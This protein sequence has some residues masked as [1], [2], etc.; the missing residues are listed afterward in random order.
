M[1][2]PRRAGD[3][4]DTV[5][6]VHLRLGVHRD[7]TPTLGRRTESRWRPTGPAHRPPGG[8][9]ARA[10]SGVGVADLV[11]PAVRVPRGD[12]V[13]PDPA[14]RNRRPAIQ[15]PRRRHR[16]PPNGSVGSAAVASL[17]S[18]TPLPAGERRMRPDSWTSSR[19]FPPCAHS[20]EPTGLPPGSRHSVRPI[21]V[22]RSQPSASRSCPHWCSC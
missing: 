10:R 18:G 11:H 21:A 19:A 6:G 16:L 1:V 12:L 15:S 4:P 17:G 7:G 5:P 20:V 3:D 9:A 14:L 13:L 22:R 2:L 8:V